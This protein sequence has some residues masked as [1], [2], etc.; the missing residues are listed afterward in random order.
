M[1]S[2]YLYSIY[3]M[4]STPVPLFDS[5]VLPTPLLDAIVRSATAV[6]GISPAAQVSAATTQNFIDVFKNMIQEK[7]AAAKAKPG[8]PP[9]Q[10]EIQWQGAAVLG[11]FITGKLEALDA[12][13]LT[14]DSKELQKRIEYFSSPNFAKNVAENAV[15]SPQTYAKA[16]ARGAEDTEGYGAFLNGL[17]ACSY[18]WRPIL[19]NYDAQRQCKG[20]V[21]LYDTDAQG[22]LSKR[23]V[24]HPLSLDIAV[25]SKSGS[26]T[27]YLCG[28]NINASHSTM[29]CEHILPVTSA[30]SHWWMM[31]KLSGKKGSHH[32]YSDKGGRELAEEYAWSHRCCNQLKTNVDFVKWGNKK[33]WEMNDKGV[34]EL[35]AN[36]SVS[37]LF[38]CQKIKIDSK[39]RTKGSPQQKSWIAKR[40]GM[41]FKRM[42]NILDGM[43][44]L[45]GV[46]AEG[47]TVDDGHEMYQLLMKLKIIGALTDSDLINVAYAQGVTE[48]PKT[49]K[50][51]KAER[52]AAQAAAAAAQRENVGQDKAA[53]LAARRARA[54]ARTAGGGPMD[55]P[56]ELASVEE[57]PHSVSAE[58]VAKAVIISEQLDDI[59]RQAGEGVD[60]VTDQ[61]RQ[62]AQ[63]NDVALSDIVSQRDAEMKDQQDV[64][65]LWNFHATIP[66]TDEQGKAIIIAAG[67]AAEAESAS[68]TQAANTA[69]ELAARVANE[70]QLTPLQTQV[71]AK[72]G[73]LMNEWDEVSQ[74]IQANLPVGVPLELYFKQLSETAGTNEYSLNRTVADLRKC[75][76]IVG[77]FLLTQ[78]FPRIVA[79][80][81]E[82][83]TALAAMGDNDGTELPRLTQ[84]CSVRFSAET[85]RYRAQLDEQVTPVSQPELNPQLVQIVNTIN[86]TD[87]DYDLCYTSILSALGEDAAFVQAAG[88]LEASV[89][90]IRLIAASIATSWT[91]NLRPTT[92]GEREWQDWITA[93]LA[94]YLDKVDGGTDLYNDY[95]T[96]L[97]YSAPTA[98]VGAQGGTDI[99]TGILA[100]FTSE[101]DQTRLLGELGELY[102]QM[103]T[104]AEYMVYNSDGK[105]IYKRWLET[106]DLTPEQRQRGIVTGFLPSGSPLGM[107]SAAASFGQGLV[108]DLDAMTDLQ[109]LAAR[110]TGAF[111]PGTLV[112]RGEKMAPSG[113]KKAK[114]SVK[115][116]VSLKARGATTR[117][118]RLLDKRSAMAQTQKS[119]RESVVKMRRAELGGGR[120]TR[121]RRQRPRKT[122]RKGQNTKN[123]KTRIRKR[124][125]KKPTRERNA[126]RRAKTNKRFVFR[127]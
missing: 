65:E 45:E 31:K 2:I 32:G 1:P 16:K 46:L 80:C 94:E 88:G 109:E 23:S 8:T 95:K 13:K 56:N 21:Y 87:N 110:Q 6:T 67:Q 102:D 19:E 111:P 60:T 5:G 99:M 4:A 125:G 71:A 36:I 66:P 51:I 114:P 17:F 26:E 122:R 74:K 106:P 108:P 118:Q 116:K 63:A 120:R 28:E 55:F 77:G 3:I 29:E 49:K 82:L 81:V 121:R 52:L 35:L 7:V 123:K 40:R 22:N 124:R 18:K 59:Y 107:E 15:P 70:V 98:P 68:T 48:I 104:D 27:C 86:E 112:T 76:E 9:S 41:I 20:L 54:A 73:E 96:Q 113:S 38:D 90:P 12:T 57:F 89:G 126:R 119:G 42:K 84:L 39:V 101:P 103:F 75:E 91:S 25:L 61:L 64:E 93:A 105:V 14:V 44:T 43:N 37:K 92:S 85:S 10:C 30:L 69:D 58:D 62:W 79:G 47:C 78:V 34:D 50:E 117:E 72:Y 83:H 97:T 100:Q 127:K 115:D 24:P 33:R 53:Q 11:E